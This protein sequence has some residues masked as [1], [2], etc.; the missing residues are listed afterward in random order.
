MITDVHASHNH[1]SCQFSTCLKVWVANNEAINTNGEEMGLRSGAN[2]FLHFFITPF[3]PLSPPFLFYRLVP[4]CFFALPTASDRY[5]LFKV[6]AYLVILTDCF[7][8][9]AVFALI[10]EFRRRVLVGLGRMACK[11]RQTSFPFVHVHQSLPQ[12]CV[13]HCLCEE[14]RNNWKLRR[15]GEFQQSYSNNS[16]GMVF[17]IFRK[18][19]YSEWILKAGF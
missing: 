8:L 7:S 13:W 17:L 12:R 3:F 2:F 14:Y 11:N 18:N 5:I 15:R 1:F 6:I 19:N 9:C 4:A 10:L 16:R